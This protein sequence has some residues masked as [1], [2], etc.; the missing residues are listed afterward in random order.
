MTIYSLSTHP[1]MSY[2]APEMSGFLLRRGIETIPHLKKKTK[3]ICPT[4]LSRAIAIIVWPGKLPL[5]H[6]QPNLLALYRC[7]QGHPFQTVTF[8][9]GT[10]YQE[11]YAHTTM[12]MSQ[13]II[14]WD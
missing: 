8:F 2:A 10:E 6:G 14:C 12:I 9:D 4:C 13:V 3:M 7:E 11:Q 5:R 1:V